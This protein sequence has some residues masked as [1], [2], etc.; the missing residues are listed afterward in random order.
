MAPNTRAMAKSEASKNSEASKSG[1]SSGSLAMSN[2]TKSSH[3]P[4]RAR[5]LMVKYDLWIDKKE[6]RETKKGKN[7]IEAA[8]NLI[9]QE[10]LSP[11]KQETLSRFMEKREKEKFSNE[12]TFI[13]VIWWKL[14]RENRQVKEPGTDVRSEEECEKII[15]TKYWDKDHLRHRRDQEFERGCLPIPDTEDDELLARL[16]EKVKGMTN[17]KPD[18]AYGLEREAFSREE[19][20][21]IDTK[22]GIAELSKGIY[23]PFFIAEFKSYQGTMTDAENQACRGGAALIN[24]LRQLKDMAPLIT[25]KNQAC[26]M[27][28]FADKEQE[29]DTGS[30]LFSLTVTP[31]NAQLFVH[32]AEKRTATKTAYHMHKV[33]KYDLEDENKVKMLRV[34]INNILDWGVGDR[35]EYVKDLL[36][37]IQKRDM[38]SPKS[39]SAS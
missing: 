32:C 35:K 26:D 36:G 7:I 16:L 28:G 18:L 30:F 34:A 19:Q 5:E 21:T 20:Y 29:H 39:G 31:E 1:K 22:P 11:T 10:R 38:D 3:D 13:D 33:Q 14:V 4:L 2:L 6:A 27:K 24:T 9:T 8:N 12:A 17:P 23:L 25:S 37:T 15:F